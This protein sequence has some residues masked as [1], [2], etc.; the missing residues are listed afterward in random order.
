MDSYIVRIYRR[1]EQASYEV[2]GV[3][4]DVE[5]EEQ[6]TFKTM[7]ELWEILAPKEKCGLK[8]GH[9]KTKKA[10]TKRSR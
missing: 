6:M 3:V 4:E 2:I 8:Q 1:K 10:P 9:A 5:M 7:D